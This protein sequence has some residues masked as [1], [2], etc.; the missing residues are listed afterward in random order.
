M[1]V[2]Y[3]SKIVYMYI[4][5]YMHILATLTA[6]INVCNVKKYNCM[7]VC[8]YISILKIVCINIDFDRSGRLINRR[9]LNSYTLLHYLNIFFNKAK[10]TII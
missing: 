7:Y 8:S 6:H 9:I 4:T 5:L 1:Y 2:C 3:V 10:L